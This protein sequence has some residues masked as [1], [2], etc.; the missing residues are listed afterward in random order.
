VTG[1]IASLLGA[2]KVASR[3]PQN[4]RFTHAGF[5]SAYRT[6]FGSDLPR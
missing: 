6:A 5:A 1:R 2:L 3:G 4:H